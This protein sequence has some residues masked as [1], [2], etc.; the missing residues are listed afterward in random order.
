MRISDWSS[1]VCSS[2][3]VL[4]EGDSIARRTRPL[5]FRGELESCAPCHARRST[6]WGEVQIGQSLEQTYRA[7]LLDEPPY[8][9][10]GPIRAARKSVVKGQRVSVR[11]DL[12]GRGYHKNKK[13]TNR[14]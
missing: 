10:D 7:A 11:V 1:D 6:L 2:D 8:H 9:A 5:A 3:L 4:A 14:H 13:T 12:G